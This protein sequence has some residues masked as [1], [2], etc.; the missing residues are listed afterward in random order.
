MNALGLSKLSVYFYS[1]PA[2]NRPVY[3]WL[4]TQTKA[5]RAILGKDIAKVEIGGPAIGRPTVDGLG[6]GLYEIR[7]TLSDGKVEARILFMVAGN[8]LV[9]LHAFIKTTRRIPRHEIAIA[10]ARMAEARRSKQP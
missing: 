8:V 6:G 2:G 9:L 4:K 5:D 10:M 7:S 3:E 1:T